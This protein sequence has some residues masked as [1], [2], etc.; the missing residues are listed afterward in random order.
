M[1]D[2]VICAWYYSSFMHGRLRACGVTGPRAHPFELLSGD[3]GQAQLKDQRPAQSGSAVSGQ[4]IDTTDSTKTAIRRAKSSAR[5]SKEAPLGLVGPLLH[6]QN[7]RSRFEQN[8]QSQFQHASSL[9]LCTKRTPNADVTAMRIV[10]RPRA[11]EETSEQRWLRAA[12]TARPCERGDS[13]A[14]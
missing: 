4:A 2:C 14:M 11:E 7:G 1:A 6:E 5:T 3:A 9:R 10:E 8:G 12:A 13:A